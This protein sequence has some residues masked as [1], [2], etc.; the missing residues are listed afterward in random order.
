MNLGATELLVVGVIFLLSSAIPIWAIIDAAIRPEPAFAA[1]GSNKST[2]LLV[3]VLTAL[4][5]NV[6]G[7]VIAI[8]YLVSTRSK[9]AAATA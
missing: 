9:L 2:Q 7:T 5:C 3:L 8:V 1:I 4:F 6:I